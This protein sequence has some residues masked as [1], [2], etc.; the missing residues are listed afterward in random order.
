MYQRRKL[1]FSL[2][3]IMIASAAFYLIFFP[4]KWL[5]TQI[6]ITFPGCIYYVEAADSVIALTIDDGPDPITTPEILG[7]LSQFNAKATFFLVTNR[8]NGNEEIV[9]RIVEEGHEI[10]NHLTRHDQASI[11]LL[12]K[13]FETEFVEADSILSRYS[14]INWFRP[15]SGWYD[16]QMI[17]T[18]NE[19]GYKCALGSVYPFDPFIPWVWFHVKHIFSNIKPGSIIILHDGEAKGQ[20]TANTLN[21]ILPVLKQK[22]FELVTLSE[23]YESA[24]ETD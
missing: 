2:A 20:R 16:Q 10:G 9:S 17:S 11:G 18:I 15:G 22:G 12:D 13:E 21:E 4:P 14:D 7:V 5:L 8:I 19:A 24:V 6:S 1:L 23:L 3:A